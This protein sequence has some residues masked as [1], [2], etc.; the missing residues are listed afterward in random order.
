MEML[1]RDKHAS[2]LCPFAVKKCHNI[3]FG[4]KSTLLSVYRVKFFWRHDTQLNDIQHNDTQHN[5]IQHN[6]T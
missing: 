1:S 2:L 6:N 4:G 3:D 5:D